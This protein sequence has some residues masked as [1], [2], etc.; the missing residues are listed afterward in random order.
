M[1]G[2]EAERSPLSNMTLEEMRELSKRTWAEV[3]EARGKREAVWAKLREWQAKNGR[4][5]NCAQ[6]VATEAKEAS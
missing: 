4:Y 6:H 5:L 1:A 3:E 2:I